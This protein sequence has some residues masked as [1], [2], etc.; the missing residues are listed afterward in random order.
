[1]KKWLIVLVAFFG[2]AAMPAQAQSFQVGIVNFGYNTFDP[3]AGT[4]LQA[5]IG[6]LFFSVDLEVNYLLG[7]IPLTTDNKFS[8]YYGA[9][10]HVGFLGFGF[11]A[12]GVGAHGAL[13]IDY[14]LQ[15]GLALGVAF[16][17]GVTFY[18]SG[19]A[20][21]AGFISPYFGGGLYLQFAI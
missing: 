13:G 5:K 11:A 20:G 4:G 19:G 9:G 3:G 12:L 6:T 7:R 10:A 17:P 21:N 18:F 14:I 8:F 16:N 1:M 15:P 2:L